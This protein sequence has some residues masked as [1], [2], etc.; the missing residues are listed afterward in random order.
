MATDPQAEHD[1][2]EIA[3]VSLARAVSRTGYRRGITRRRGGRLTTGGRRVS[4]IGT[5]KG[6][7]GGILMPPRYLDVIDRTGP[8]AIGHQKPG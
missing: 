3:T 4:L 1:L 6:Q 2:F 5:L 7:C 8:R